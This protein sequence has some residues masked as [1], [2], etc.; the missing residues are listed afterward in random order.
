MSLRSTHSTF[1]FGVWL[2]RTGDACIARVS[3]PEMAFCGTNA[4]SSGLVVGVQ[5]V[6]AIDFRLS[7]GG[8]ESRAFDSAMSGERHRYAGSIGRDAQKGDVV[9]MTNHFEPETSEGS[10]YARERCV[11][12]EARHFRRR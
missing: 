6:V 1:R 12:R 11:D 10:H 2:S 4:R 5:E 3:A 8:S 7:Q 9:A